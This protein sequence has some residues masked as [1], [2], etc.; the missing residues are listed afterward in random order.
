M[1]YQVVDAVGITSIAAIIRQSGLQKI[2][3][4]KYGSAKGTLPVFEDDDSKTNDKI[5]KGFQDWAN[6]IL[7]G[8]QYNDTVYELLLYNEPMALDDDDDENAE[9]K[10]RKRGHSKANKMKFNFQLFRPG[11]NDR[12][13]PQKNVTPQSNLTPENLSD[14]INSEIMKNT[15]LQRLAQIE[16]SIDEL[17]ELYEG[18]EEG[19]NEVNGTTK[20]MDYLDKLLNLLSPQADKNAV[21]LNG[22]P[23]DPKTAKD[24]INKAIQIL[25]KHD[26]SIDLH[27]LKLANLAETNKPLFAQI[28]DTLEKM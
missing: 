16:S 10:N 27:L 8:N 23:N 7:L 28:V 21:M 2:S 4:I 12:N 20:Q 11:P 3:I 25:Y 5:V 26:K 9:P 17:Y 19:K 1:S 15:L 18:I 24:N 6:N 22:T 14:L 13:E